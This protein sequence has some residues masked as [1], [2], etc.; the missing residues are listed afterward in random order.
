MPV[1]VYKSTDAGA[2]VVNGVRGAF[3]SLLDACLVNGYGDKASASWEKSFSSTNM[4]A[5]RAPLGNRFF[6]EVDEYA[7]QYSRLRAYRTMTGFGAGTRPFPNALQRPTGVFAI[8][9]D[10]GTSVTSRPWIVIASSTAFY[11]FIGHNVTDWSVAS[12]A[13]DCVMFGDCVSNILDD[14]CF[15]MLVGRDNAATAVS[16]TALFNRLTTGASVSAHHY[17]AGDYLNAS[18]S[19]VVGTLQS[20]IAA[21]A[22]CGNAGGFYPDPITGG[23]LLDYILVSEPT[24]LFRGKLPGVF[25]PLHALPGNNWNTFAGRGAFAGKNFILVQNGGTIGRVAFSL[26]DSDWA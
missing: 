14:P 15:T 1:S 2:P 9:S 18:D 16:N 20:P 19:I 17:C 21:S 11:S 5:Y 12:T 24:R 7:N 8:T 3:I 26:D 22:V 25:N 23:I 4:A 10:V 6:L 13:V